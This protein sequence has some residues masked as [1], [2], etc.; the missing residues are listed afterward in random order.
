MKRSCLVLVLAG[1]AALGFGYGQSITPQAA[2]SQTTLRVNSRAVLVDVVVTDRHGRPVTG[3]KQDAFAVTEQ[4]KPQVVD[5]FE[6]H[7]ASELAVPV[8]MPQLPPDVFSNFSPFPQPPAVTVL[9]LDSLNTRMESQSVVHKQAMNFL[10]SAKPGSRMAIFAMGLGL[11]FI[12]GFN[13]DPAVLAAALNSKKNNEVETSVMLKG[14]DETNAQANVVGMM[15]AAAPS[16]P[17]VTATV[18][19]PAMIASLQTFL[20][21]NDTSQQF[22]RMFV[23]LSN[24]QRLAAFLEG[25]P[26]RKNIIWFAE[27]V[28]SLYV[29][30]TDASGGPQ[31]GNPGIA[32]ELK[33]TLA[34]LAAARA[35][36][37]PVSAEGVS[38]SGGGLYTAENNLS[39]GISQDS[40]LM[41]ATSVGGASGAAKGGGFADTLTSASVNRNADQA[42]A[43]LLAEESGGKAYSNT[44]G[45][46]QVMADISST[47]GDFYTLSYSPS[48]S[49]M[50]GSYRTIDVK[51]GGGSYKLSYRRGYFAVDEALPGSSLVS[52]NQAMEK[53]AAQNGG[54]VDPLL[55]FMD[56][57]MPQSEQILYKARIEPVG[58]K[59]NETESEKA[60]SHYVIHFAVDLKDLNLRLDADG[61]HKGMLNVSLR[62]YDRY[63]NIASRKDH[64]VP[65]SIKPDTW[66]VYRDTGLQLH[67]EIAVPKGNFWLRTGIYDQNS[68]KV[69]T[70]EI[71]LSS[72][73]P[74]ETSQK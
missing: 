68:H 18:A 30:G 45:L 71:P 14:Q 3:L 47:S 54:V 63:G 56:L 36:I 53:I 55:P 42:N 59:D 17:G 70:M 8:E 35:A 32:D 31:S 61:S 38:V 1:S 58:P 60:K 25:F 37:Y 21:E 12:Q 62:A 74:L 44:N 64:L 5:F 50:D 69:G 52:R 27:K 26:G 65:L 11:H 48:N 19:S 13:D 33:K 24:L 66:A 15:S 39:K 9:L 41:G 29:T 10:K 73:K 6:E 2:D 46:S 7:R 34:M 43:Q 16:G 72:V 4:G 22:D 40:Q 51:V 49:K 20:S 23:T 57:G 67:A 28:P